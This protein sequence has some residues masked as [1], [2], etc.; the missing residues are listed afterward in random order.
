MFRFLPKLSFFQGL[1]LAATASVSFTSLQ[2]SAVELDK[3]FD[4]SE[5]AYTTMAGAEEM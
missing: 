4:S 3:M 2:V 1:T 5:P